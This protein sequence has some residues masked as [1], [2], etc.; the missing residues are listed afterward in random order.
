MSKVDEILKTVED[1]KG[2]DAPA[3]KTSAKSDTVFVALNRVNGIKFALA[4]GERVLINGNGAP[5]VGR[6]M[7]VIPIGGYGLT[8]ISREA[9]EYI[10]KTYGC[11]EIFQN[12]LIFATDKR[13]DTEM[14]SVNRRSLRHGLEPIDPEKTVT[15]AVKA[16]LRN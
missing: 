5:L 14:E 13:G 8:E 11:M 16:G 2:V 10:E 7:G 12:G 9:W 4:N 3:V 1:A 6:E 15:T